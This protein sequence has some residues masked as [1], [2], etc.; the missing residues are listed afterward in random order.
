MRP[1]YLD[2]NGTTPV[3]PHVLDVMLP[4]LRDQFGNASSTTPLG[5][6]ARDA[7][8][9][10]RGQVASLIGAEPPEVVFTSGGTEASNHAI[11]GFARQAPTGRRK[12]VTSTIEHPATEQPCRALLAQGFAVTLVPATKQGIIDLSQ[13]ERL[14][15]KET[16]LVS[17]I[18]AQNEV[19]TLQPV[20][21]VALMAR[22]AGTPM[23]VDA[24]QSLGKVPVDVAEWQIDALTIAGHKLYAPKGIGALYV[25][26]GHRLPSVMFGAGQEQGLRPGTENVAFIAGLGEACRLAQARLASEAE[27]LSD[28]RDRLWAALAAGIPDLVRVG[29]GADV[30]PNTLNVLFPDVVGNDLLAAT[31]EIAASTGSACHAGDSKPSAVLLALGFTAPVAL[32]AVRLTLGRANQEAD[33]DQAAAFLIERWRGLAG[34]RSARA[35]R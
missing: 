15:D 34:H 16:A 12:I 1:I 28:L 19:G 21:A 22:E 7:I 10:A 20:Q 25:R 35:R 3:D 2:H 33:V 14:I 9:T 32:G 8:E 23:H 4:F 24:S 11:F 13:A 27:R 17:L 18:H 6:K 5:R 31:P 26:A 30:L 29:D